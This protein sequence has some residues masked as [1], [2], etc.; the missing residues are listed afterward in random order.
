M[1][2]RNFN[3]MKSV[4]SRL[5]MAEEQLQI[6]CKTLRKNGF[7]ETADELSRELRLIRNFSKPGGLLDIL[8]KAEDWPDD[9]P[10]IPSGRLLRDAEGVKPCGDA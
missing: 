10:E 6:T 8:E 2:K 7:E 1:T 4:R 9:W 5:A 3:C